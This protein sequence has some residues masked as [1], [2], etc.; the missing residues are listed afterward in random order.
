MPNNKNAWQK[1]LAIL[2]R[3]M[4]SEAWL[5]YKLKKHGFSDEEIQNAAQKARGYKLL[6]DQNYAEMLA[7]SEQRRGRSPQWIQ[8][9]LRA[10]GISKE[11]TQETLNALNL[12]DT[13]A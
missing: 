5:S 2:S 3:R 12:T 13:Q 11:I 1:T 9:S 10:H 4:Q 8:S 6:D 7:K